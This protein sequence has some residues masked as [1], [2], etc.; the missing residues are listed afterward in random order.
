MSQTIDIP[1]N[2]KIPC[3]CTITSAASNLRKLVK[4]AL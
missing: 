4:D 3:P 2:M 1:A